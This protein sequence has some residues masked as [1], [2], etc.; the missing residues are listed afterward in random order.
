MGML[1]LGLGLGLVMDLSILRLL[2]CDG[3]LCV[4]LD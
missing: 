2:F 3:V 1:G 4:R